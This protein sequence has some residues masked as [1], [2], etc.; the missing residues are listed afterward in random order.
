MYNALEK[1]GYDMLISPQYI[2]E[3]HSYLFGLIKTYEVTVKGYGA[4]IKRIHQH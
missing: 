1:G 2:T 4:K 3:K